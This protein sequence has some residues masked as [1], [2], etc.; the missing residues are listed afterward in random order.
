[1]AERRGRVAIVWEDISA[2]PFAFGPALRS[3]GLTLDEDC[4]ENEAVR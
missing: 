1:M 2:H 3:F 4:G